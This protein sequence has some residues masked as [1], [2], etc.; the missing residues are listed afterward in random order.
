[1]FSDFIS[2]LERDLRRESNKKFLFEEISLDYKFKMIQIFNK[3]IK[4]EIQSAVIYKLLAEKIVGY[5]RLKELFEQHSREEFAHFSKIVTYASTH[6][7]LGEI[8]FEE[9]TNLQALPNLKEEILSFIQQL[10]EESIRDYINAANEADKEGDT[11]TRIFFDG[12]FSEEVIHNGNLTI[13]KE[14]IYNEF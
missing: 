4:S 10:E 14:E 3:A 2:L 1:M 8:F 9:P 11:E 7:I 13:F 6:G 12:L 5:D